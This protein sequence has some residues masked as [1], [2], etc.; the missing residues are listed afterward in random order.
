M[1]ATET[2]TGAARLP[3][4]TELLP[5]RPDAVVGL[6]TEAGAALVRGAGRYA[7]CIVEE[8]DFV[9]VGAPGDAPGPGRPAEPT[10]EV[11]PPAGGAHVRGLRMPWLAARVDT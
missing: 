7:D 6:Q 9:E 5:G 2:R 4:P 11:P 10:H 3:G 1:A 8:V